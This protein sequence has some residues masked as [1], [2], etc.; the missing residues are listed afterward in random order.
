[1]I[2]RYTVLNET[3]KI[4]MV[5]RPYQYFACEAIIEKVENNSTN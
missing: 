1:M 5:L 3:Y 4:L 2:T